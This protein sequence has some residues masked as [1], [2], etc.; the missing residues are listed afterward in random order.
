MILPFHENPQDVCVCFL[1]SY[2]SPCTRGR[3]DPS[4]RMCARTRMHTCTY[5]GFLVSVFFQ[6]FEVGTFSSL[7]SPFSTSRDLVPGPLCMHVAMSL[8]PPVQQLHFQASR[9]GRSQ[10]RSEERPWW[11]VGESHAL[12]LDTVWQEYIFLLELLMGWEWEDSADCLCLIN[13]NWY[14]TLLILRWYKIIF[15]KINYKIMYFWST[16]I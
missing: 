14:T 16:Q 4:V 8:V 11:S 12:P 2:T 9:R 13:P 15:I 7:L 10:M 3:V 6:I 5:T 1:R